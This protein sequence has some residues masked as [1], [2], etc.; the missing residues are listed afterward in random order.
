[1]SICA[2]ILKVSRTTIWTKHSYGLLGTKLLCYHFA[3]SSALESLLSCAVSHVL[4]SRFFSH[5]KIV[6]SVTLPGSYI[7][8]F[9]LLVFL[10][11]LLIFYSC[12]YTFIRHINI[13]LKQNYCISLPVV[14]SEVTLFIS[15]QYFSYHK[16]LFNSELLRTYAT[17][18]S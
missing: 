14:H 5:I 8:I 2:V 17:L 4:V 7:G 10:K 6:D 1:M 18:K 3:F 15:I 16:Q 13:F 12:L 9:T 11:Q